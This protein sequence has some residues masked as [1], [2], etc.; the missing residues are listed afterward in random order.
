MQFD[1]PAVKKAVSDAGADYLAN[2][3][4]ASV[5]K[6][7][8]NI[9]SLVAQGADVLIVLAGFGDGLMPSVAS[10]IQAGVPVIAYDRL[11]DAPGTLY[12]SFDNLEVGRMQA[13]ELLKAAP[14]GNYLFI[15]G[16]QADPNADFLRSGQEEVLHEAIASGAI[17]NV[18]ESYIDNW[19]G[20]LAGVAL[21][22]A[23]KD[24]DVDAV[25]AENDGMAIGVVAALARHRVVGTAVSGMDGAPPALNQ[26]ALGTQTVD[27]WKDT[28]LLGKA[29]GEAAVELCRGTGV[30]GI[31]GVSPFTTAGGHTLSSLLIKPV[32]I[33]KN[34]LDAVVEAGWITGDD[35]CQGVP[36]GSVAACP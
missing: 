16:D 3:A 1:E 18:G 4:E 31:R 25:A 21:E 2:D 15:K 8:K 11:I 36:A 10:A 13:R 23:L 17:K 32:A 9:D 7:A 26:V 35:L 28:R 6:Q 27:I 34:N 24:H 12:L 29:A 33:T 19:S 20:D 5:A 14:T 30:D 22:R